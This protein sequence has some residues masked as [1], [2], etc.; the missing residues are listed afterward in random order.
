ML[1]EDNNRKPG[2]FD[3]FMLVAGC[4]IVI[5]GLG[6]IF[7]HSF[8]FLSEDFEGPDGPLP[9]LLV[10]LFGFVAFCYSLKKIISFKKD[11]T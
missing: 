4:V 10:L 1:P 6:L 5:A 2:V 8:S 9:G 11:D 7:R 3:Y